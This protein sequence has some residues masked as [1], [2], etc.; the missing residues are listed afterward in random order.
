MTDDR[1]PA[2]LLLALLN[3]ATFANAMRRN[4]NPCRIRLPDDPGARAA[5]IF[6]ARRRS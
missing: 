5:L 1:V 2:P 6:A 4:G 3:G